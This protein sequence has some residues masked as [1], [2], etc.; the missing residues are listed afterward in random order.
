MRPR[1]SILIMHRTRRQAGQVMPVAVIIFIVLCAIA[2]LAVDGGRDYL[3]KRNAQN[4][5]D[6]SALAAAKQLA[7][8]GNLNQVVAS[9][10]N[11]VIAA[12]DFAANNG[13]ATLYSTSCDAASG[14]S[15]TATWFD[16]PGFSCNATAGFTNKVSVHSPAIDI[17]GSP[18]PPICLGS[19]QYSCFQVTIT[20]RVSQLFASVLGIDTAFVTV[21]GTAHATLP[22]VLYNTPPPNALIL[23]EPYGTN[24]GEGKQCFDATKPASRAN[25]ICDSASNCPTF[26]VRPGA[27]INIYGYDGAVLTPPNDRTTLQ[28]NG[29][30]VVQS[31]S[32]LCD[33][34]N[35]AV[36]AQNTVVGARGFAVPSGT[37]VYCSNYGSGATGNSTP[38]ST[39]VQTPLAELDGAQTS[40]VSPS[41]WA[42]SVNTS[43]LPNCGALVLNGGPVSGSC[44]KAG[45]PYVIMPGI[46]QYIAI[47]HG[48]YEFDP[49]LYDITGSA[50]VNSATGSGYVANGI[51][52]SKETAADFDLCTG[53][54]PNSCP[55]L[56]AGIWFGH[57]GGS[58]GA[59]V[60]PVSGT[61]LGSGSGTS[62]GGGDATVISGSGIVLRLEPG[63]GGF[64][65]TNEVQGLQLAG[66]GVGSLSAV[67]GA[68]LLFDNEGNTFVHLDARASKRN[69]IQ[70]VLYQ[71]ANATAG[72]FEM[73][74]G[75]ASNPTAAL[76]GQVIG[77]SFTTFGT[78]GTLDF[79]SG[80]GAG[81]VGGIATSGKNETSLISSVSLTSGSPGFSVLTLNYTD[82]WAMDGYN[83]Y[84]KVNNG[85]PVFF[86]Q[87]I[88]NPTP[89][90]G[91]PQPPPNNN[92]GDQFPAYPNPGSPGPY[93]VNPLDTTDWSLALPNS[94]GAT[95]ELKGSWTWGH[96]MDIPGATE[97]AYAAQEIYTF[98]TPIGNYVAI[99]M[100]VTD[101]DHCGDYALASYTFKNVG[102]PGGGT[103]TVGT[104]QLV[105]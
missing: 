91:A 2:G 9:G 54:L 97:G 72:G 35:G 98:P 70:G 7:L 59:Y 49:G 20:T 71:T 48:T 65:S 23:R 16:R 43:G 30:M 21:G 56:T 36:C 80:Y 44:A 47:N 33:P 69:G 37:P 93:T 25:L 22:G 85:T 86:S 73:N 100:F 104:V 52:H 90:A 79:R 63:A 105:Q 99:T 82:E 95:L 57:G 24:C 5:A 27:S 92:P 13:F 81:A 17:P 66:A 83:A 94:G 55:S 89:A 102:T 75:L 14:G 53:G 29:A 68:P 18:V 74:P 76:T 87:G 50:P 46:Y 12:H 45:E 28:S 51:D 42:P 31:R 96:Q 34:Y 60:A 103:Q 58:Y 41:A 67:G 1:R 88:W 6:F 101:G 84:I 39:T 3:T 10:S 11:P 15:F 40:F 77:Y 19:S 64:V 26:W 38:C 32:T 61:C 62:G 4:A 78:S 8:S